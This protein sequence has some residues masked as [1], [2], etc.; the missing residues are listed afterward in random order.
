MKRI[1]T[2]LLVSAFGITSIVGGMTIIKPIEAQAIDFV[3][4]KAKKANK[5][6]LPEI[7]SVTVVK[8]DMIA[9]KI[10]EGFGVA[11]KVK[12]YVK[13]KG[14]KIRKVE[15]S[16]DYK[17]VQTFLERNGD[18]GR[19]ITDSSGKQWLKSYARI[20]NKRTN[21]KAKAK[22]YKI[23]SKN[24][25]RYAKKKKKT[26]SKIRLKIKPNG[27]TFINHDQFSYE[28][29]IYIKLPKT[30]REGKKYTI[31][32]T[33]TKTYP[34]KVSFV[35][36][37]KKMRNEAVHVNQVG[38]RPDDIGKVAS[39]SLWMGTGGK[40]KLPSTVN[41]KIL[42]NKTRKAVYSGKGY[43][44][45]AT[46]PEIYV[47]RSGNAR[48]MNGTDVCTFDFSDFTKKGTYVIYV[49]GYGCSYPFK[50]ADNTWESAF[51]VSMKGFLHQRSGIAIDKSF[52]DYNRPIGYSPKDGFKIYQS[53]STLVDSGN[54]LS[55][56]GATFGNSV[57]NNFN[58]LIQGW[59]QNKDGTVIATDV[60]GDPNGCYGGY[61]D[62]GDWDRRSQH[63]EASRYQIELLLMYPR[64]FENLKLSLP[65]DEK[66]DHLPDILNEALWNIDFYRRMATPEG[67]IRGGIE[68]VE[69]PVS[70]E[71]SWTE[72]LVAMA[73]AP[74]AWS[75]Y[76]YAG[77][78]A[79]VAYYLEKV[80]PE[81][82]RAEYAEKA[83][84]YR[85]S[86]IKAYE[87]ANVDFQERL[88]N[89][90]GRI[91]ETGKPVGRQKYTAAS[92]DTILSE[93]IIA[94][95]YLLLLTGEAQYNEVI[96]ENNRPSLSASAF[97]YALLPSEVAH[98]NFQKR[99]VNNLIKQA[100]LSYS[101][102][103]G[104]AYFITRLNNKEDVGY[105]GFYTSPYAYNL[106]RTHYLTGVEKYLEAITKSCQVLMGSNQMNLPMMT[107]IGKN[108]L[109]GVFLLDVVEAGLDMPSGYV[110]YGNTSI[111]D[112]GDEYYASTYAPSMIPS[113]ERWPIAENYLD[114]TT[115]A[116]E[117][118]FTIH[119]TF[120]GPNFALGYLAARGNKYDTYTVR[121]PQEE[122]VYPAPLPPGQGTGLLTEFYISHNPIPT[123][124]GLTKVGE[125]IQPN[126]D[127]NWS[128]NIE[129]I[130]GLGTNHYTVK[131]TGKITAQ[132]TGRHIIT[133]ASDDG[134][135][136]TIG[137]VEVI[138]QWR[139]M[140]VSE[141]LQ[142]GEIVMLA[143]ETYEFE[144]YYFENEG[145]SQEQL[146]WEGPGLSA[147][148]IPG[149]QFYTPT[150]GPELN[151]IP[152]QD[153]Y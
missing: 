120:S 47:D 152:E 52:G 26:A 96:L 41:F 4:E 132:V 103:N 94:A 118:E 97:I 1:A 64:Y 46:T 86:A 65:A 105:N 101:L 28:T 34:K 5:K 13:K 91:D 67:G 126:V 117:N 29:N 50:I 59:K 42:N 100:D 87:W 45:T 31:N 76:L 95:T 139:K 30:M 44:H 99:C 150:T 7:R 114:V 149:T 53:L 43:T 74:D 135:K 40:L 116:M 68:T 22:T 49:P 136:L 57:N 54:G 140:A 56:I 70:G 134:L 106:V 10:Q 125:Q 11:S 108:K 84:M 110:P 128:D 138:N 75:S 131:W 151:T 8:D 51:K 25:K 147:Q 73:Y 63:M 62:A 23:T 98:T 92:N 60:N 113:F 142:T 129:P 21:Y 115:L 104:N 2:G 3:K 90:N 122:K 55:A 133:A 137:G 72:S 80:I 36:N 82:Y 27:D 88:D 107:G 102:C 35:Y 79:G 153:L 20:T 66:N 39:F 18:G 15:E 14:D 48:N 32:L 130:A 141:G 124:D 143:G 112:F 38:F 61:F 16:G 119:Q 123:V 83:K 24:D 33:K 89:E 37:P 148:V 6:K 146:T 9:L 78:A 144:L 12:K 17:V 58:L 93:K 71:T 109:T 69:H 111:H 127:I 77:C 85:D 121:Y 145:F 81:A 19:I